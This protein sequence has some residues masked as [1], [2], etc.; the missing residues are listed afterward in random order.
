MCKK[1]ISVPKSSTESEVDAGLRM[2]VSPLLIFGIWSEVLHSSLNQPTGRLN[3]CRNEPSEKRSNAKAKKHF[4][5]LED[6]GLTNLDS[7]TSNGKL[8]RFDA[9]ALYFEDHGAVI[10]MIIKGRSPTMR[11]GSRTH[12]VALVLLFDR[13]NLVDSTDSNRI[14]TD[15][16]S[17]WKGTPTHPNDDA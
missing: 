16:K 7:F 1:Q 11:H 17:S 8:S 12:R 14:G 2:V 3:L 6:P 13:I 4:N 9:S 10:K 5:P 15:C